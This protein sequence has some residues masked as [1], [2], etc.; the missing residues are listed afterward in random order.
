[1]TTDT[2]A[3]LDAS[4]TEVQF[5]EQVVELAHLKGWRVCHFRPGRTASGWRTAV[6]FDAQGWPDLCLVRE[7]VVCAELKSEHGVLS[8]LQSDWITALEAAK[9]EVYVFRP[10]DWPK[11]ERVL[12]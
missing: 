7:R 11:V 6:S 4:T 12:A 2:R 10:S 9:A 1:M 5:M 3:L 8:T